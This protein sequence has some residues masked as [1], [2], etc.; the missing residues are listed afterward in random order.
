M[1]SLTIRGEIESVPEE[2]AYEAMRR[3]YQ[4]QQAGDKTA[5]LIRTGDVVTE[6]D[7]TGTDISALTAR[8][9]VRHEKALKKMGIA[10][11]PPVY[12]PGMRLVAVGDASFQI[13]RC[14][15]EES[16][17]II[18]S[19]RTLWRL[20]RQ[21]ERHERIIKLSKVKMLDD[22]SLSWGNGP[23]Y[24]EVQAL[25]QLL[26]R[27]GVFPNGASY[28]TAVEPGLRAYNWRE[29]IGQMDGVEA[30]MRLRRNPLTG[31]FSVF[32]VVSPTYGT[33]DIDELSRHMAPAF[34]GGELR[35]SVLYDS[36]RTNL[37]IDG[38]WNVDH[39]VD[40]ASGDVF[41]V[42]VQIWTND[43]GRGGIWV[44]ATAL[45]KICLNLLILAMG[46]AALYS[47][48]HQGDMTD[49]G[50]EVRTA[51]NGAQAQ[52]DVF[53]KEWGIL[54]QTPVETVFNTKIKSLED[55][56]RSIAPRLDSGVRRDAMVEMLLDNYRSE[57]GGT[58]ADVLN[59]VSRSH[60]SDQIDQYRREK[61]EANGRELVH[62]YAREDLRR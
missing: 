12:A 49:V 43:S 56:F 18:D 48:H 37:R 53:A 30:K 23:V 41:Q 57:P 29:R 46:E 47:R 14:T 35:G 7:Q 34:E 13:S 4:A 8:R 9:I 2:G 55:L 38:R 45:R 20:I 32:A 3:F 50:P 1:L 40:L 28:L 10:L 33:M 61:I 16:P 26:Q 58:L 42:G 36:A 21:E 15:W 52:F 44:H 51:I 17:Q 19:L 22:G 5:K 54:R 31:R 11:S 24:L 59:A 25:K 39:V 27:A 62:L 6:P 60:L